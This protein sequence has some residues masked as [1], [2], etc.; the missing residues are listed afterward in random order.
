MV[1]VLSSKD[2][3]FKFEGCLFFNSNDFF[4]KFDGFFLKFEGFLFKFKGFLFKVRRISV[5][6][7]NDSPI[8]IYSVRVLPDIGKGIRS[9]SWPMFGASGARCPV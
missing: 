5:L 3:F 2:F 9:G 1:S 8:R 7:S 6:S 4:C